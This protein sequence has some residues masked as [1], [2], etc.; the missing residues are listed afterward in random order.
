MDELLK[1]YKGPED[2]T[3]EN[4]ILKQFRTDQGE[5]AIEVPRDRNSSLDPKIVPKHSREFK[6]FDDT[7][8]LILLPVDEYS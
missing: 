6:G 7:I 3:G 2:L 8:L 4:D 5:L 1:S